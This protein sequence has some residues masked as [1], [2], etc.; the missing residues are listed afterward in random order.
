MQPSAGLVREI[1]DALNRGDVDGMLARMHPDFEW[2]PLE[3]SPIARVYRGHDQV[4]HYVEDWWA[5]LDS[6]RLHLD[7]VSEVDGRVVTVVCGTGRGRASGLELDSRFCQVWTVRDGLAVAMAEYATRDQG[8]AMLESANVEVV[9]SVYDAWAAEDLP[10]PARLFDA[11]I[12]YVNPPGAVE[13]GTRHGLAAFSQAVHDAFEGWEAWQIEPERFLPAGERVAVVVRY[14]AHWRA[15]GVDV[16]AHESALWTVR[17]GRIVRYEWFH[18][19]DD[20]LEAAG[21]RE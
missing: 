21:L 6:I 8:L 5:A 9:R 4:R 15:S 1:I 7:D 12:E 10:G 2:T 16:E 17:N 3:S 18:G 13:P 11:Q 19:P 14:R 20:A